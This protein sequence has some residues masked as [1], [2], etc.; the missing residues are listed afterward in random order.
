MRAN[1]ARA[2]RDATARD[3][4]WHDVCGVE[5]VSRSNA[6]RAVCVA[7]RHLALVRAPA[8]SARLHAIDA[9]CYHMGG[10]LLWA[11]IEEVPGRGACAVCPWHRYHVAL[12]T[13][14]R[15]YRDLNGEYVGIARKQRVHEVKEDDASGRVLVRLSRDEEAWESDRYAM[16]APPPASAGTGAG[17][18]SGHVFAAGRGRGGIIGGGFDRGECG[19]GARTSGVRSMVAQTM[20]G[21]DGV[22]PWAMTGSGG[23]SSLGAFGASA[24][25]VRRVRKKVTFSGEG[26][27]ASEDD[28]DGIEES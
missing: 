24:M 14:E 22:A 16:K 6:R 3:D 11:E 1:A 4:G 8:P 13:G 2:T 23:D 9:T 19:P 17:P 12:T 21:G 18:R 10:P 15:V 20:R 28:G 25:S 27:G 5:E 7:G 26:D